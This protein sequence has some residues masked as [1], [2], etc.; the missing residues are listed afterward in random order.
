MGVKTLLSI[1]ENHR[2]PHLADTGTR[3]L[4]QLSETYGR[5]GK[6]VLQQHA[7]MYATSL[8]SEKLQDLDPKIALLK[9]RSEWA[10]KNGWPGIS[11]Q[12]QFYAGTSFF[13]RGKKGPGFEYMLR[14]YEKMEQMDSSQ[15]PL[16]YHFSH[17]LASIYYDLGDF[18]NCVRFATAYE[19]TD[20][21]WLPEHERYGFRNTM[22][23][24]WL[25]LKKYDSANIFFSMA[26]QSARLS[27]DSLWMA[28]SHGNMGYSLFQQ[29]RHGE[30]LPLL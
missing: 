30:V 16:R 8:Q 14:A 6:P 15:V 4:E 23:M 12:L 1:F 27:G 9:N 13:F 2:F 17:Q 20:L 7:W 26:H 11:A 18:E 3:L 10:S 29:G 28:L 5:Q 19:K 24:A 25:Q 22:G 21:R